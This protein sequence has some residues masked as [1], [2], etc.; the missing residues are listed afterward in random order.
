M[1]ALLSTRTAG[2]LVVGALVAMGASPAI[3]AA[4][5]SAGTETAYAGHAYG[6]AVHVGPY[7]TQ[8]NAADVSLCTKKPAVAG[9]LSVSPLTV[10]GAGFIGKVTTSVASKTVAANKVQAVGTTTVGKTVLAAGLVSFTSL[11]VTATVTRTGTSYKNSGSLTFTGLEV[12]GLPVSATP[13]AGASMKVDG[14]G[15]LL[16]NQRKSSV[17]GGAHSES[18]TALTLTVD[19]GNI[20]ALDAGTIVLGYADALLHEP[21]HHMASGSSYGTSVVKG[22]TLIDPRQASAAVP[23]GGSG[24]LTGSVPVTSVNIPGVLTTGS[25]VSTESSQDSSAAT[26]AL[27]TST[28]SNVS[29][30]GGLIT[31]D[32]VVAKAHATRA[33]SKVTTAVTGT[34]VVGL[35]VQGSAAKTYSGLATIT[36]P[37]IGY[38]YLNQRAP[39]SSGVQVYGL[40][41]VLTVGHAGL[42]KQTTITV[43]SARAAVAP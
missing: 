6:Y 7:M 23:C 14:V 30:L 8:G 16:F 39:G 18:V 1:P 34:S 3:A 40:Q 5:S 41:L 24:G 25:S 9:P 31:A 37:G 20:S 4:A 29:L 28:T 22:D 27:T 38:L 11:K 35:R 15:T 33:G 32:K 17:R 21:V 43:G 36:I 2:C 19:P 10:P 13:K 26:S 12:N 42:K